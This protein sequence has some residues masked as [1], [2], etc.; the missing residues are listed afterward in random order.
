MKYRSQIESV[1]HPS[2][3]IIKRKSIKWTPLGS[4]LQSPFG[5]KNISKNNWTPYGLCFRRFPSGD[6]K[7]MII[8]KMNSISIPN[9]AQNF[10]FFLK[11]QEY[12][13][14][15]SAISARLESYNAFGYHVEC[16][17]ETK[18][19]LEVIYFLFIHECPLCFEISLY[20]D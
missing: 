9:G 4:A 19:T 11:V 6:K 3:T 13:S 18:I 2:L 20:E 5:G 14:T 16:K 7:G 15:A 1:K 12:L 8:K 17:L 10:I